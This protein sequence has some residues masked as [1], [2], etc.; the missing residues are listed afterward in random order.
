M[1]KMSAA[2]VS[3]SFSLLRHASSAVAAAAVVLV[4]PAQVMAQSTDSVRRRADCA[5][6]ELSL[7]VGDKVSAR[8]RAACR[9][10]KAPR[11]APPISRPRIGA[12]KYR[13]PDILR[14]VK[15]PKQVR[16]RKV[17][18]TRPAWVDRIPS[19]RGVFFGVGQGK[20]L[21]MGFQRAA[22]VI[23]GQVQMHIH[24]TFNINESES[25]RRRGNH[26]V[27][28]GRSHVSESSQMLVRGLVD[29]VKLEDNYKDPRTGQIWVLASLNIAALRA[30]EDALVQAVYRIFARATARLYVH[31]KKR[32]V[33]HQP[34]LHEL[35]GVLAEVRRLGLSKIGRKMRPRWSVQY[36][37][38]KRLVARF[39]DCLETK[40]V[41]IS[42][43]QKIE[44]ETCPK[45]VDDTTIILSL[46]CKRFPV[47][48]ARV[49]AHVSGGMTGLPQ[50]L[51]SDSKGRIKVSLGKVFGQGKVKLGFT[52]NLKDVDGAQYLG[53]FQPSHRS[54]ICFTSTQPARIAV[55]L[56]GVKGKEKRIVLNA[57][58]TFVAQKWGAKIV[59]GY[60]PL[61]GAVRVQFGNTSKVMGSFAVP[62]EI[63]IVVNSDQGKLFEKK[64]KVGSVGE[65]KKGVRAQALNNLLRAI[66]RW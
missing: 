16:T 37:S 28:T 51:E 52:H 49:K 17:H 22:V 19:R 36:R 47:I 33:I 61:K 63:S 42:Q 35:I 65:T 46:T 31:L 50:K 24:S 2:I 48:E 60:A 41:F 27:N 44:G 39:T 23:A 7:A 25:S 10:Y 11:R 26:V 3:G 56:T 66:Q 18:R 15:P 21:T 43:G 62:V 30:K 1:P 45:I 40:A 5:Q 38:F 32:K 64:G 12:K 53:R 29:D 55:K 6:V 34:A 8:E 20:T 14:D 13:V 59:R 9:T 4:L 58:K 57:L 54:T